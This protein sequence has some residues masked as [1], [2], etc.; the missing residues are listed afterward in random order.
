[1]TVQCPQ[2]DGPAKV[3]ADGKLDYHLYLDDLTPC[4]GVGA[5][6]EPPKKAKKKG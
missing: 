1:M 5:D 2:C 3:T 4:K 6:A